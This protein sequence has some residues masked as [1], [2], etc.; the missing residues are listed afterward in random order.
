MIHLIEKYNTEVIPAMM[1]KFGYKNK[2][3]VPKIVKVVVNTGFGREV[4]GKAVEEQK[5]IAEF[6][7]AELTLICGQRAVKTLSKKSIASFK[8]REGMA[9]GAKVT[10]RG[11]KM[12]DF[13]ER[14]IH[15]V[16]PRTRDFK[17]IE[18]KSMDRNG[19]LNVAVREHI[20]F[21]EIL[22]EK[23]K[24]IF[25]LEVTVVTTAKKQE[26]GLELLKLLGFPIKPAD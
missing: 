4:A 14:L 26:E 8:I 16:L 20:V 23:A 22:P 3:A 25:G 24:N 11:K 9:L 18:R 12:V 13:L 19:N 7:A 10:L 2:M 6:I 17:G 5:K 1:Q 15:L 21:P